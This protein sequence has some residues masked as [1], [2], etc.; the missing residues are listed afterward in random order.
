MK[1]NSCATGNYGRPT[2]KDVYVRCPNRLRPVRN[3]DTI[4]VVDTG[5][6]GKI[7]NKLTS[8]GGANVRLTS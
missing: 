6:A 8:E 4:Q 5:V 1:G 3:D 2:D 7:T